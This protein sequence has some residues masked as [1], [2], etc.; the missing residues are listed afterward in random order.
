VGNTAPEVFT[1]QLARAAG[2]RANKFLYKRG[3]QK[4]D[5]DDVIYAAL[6]WCWENRAN[7]SLTTTLET[8]F[9]N[10]VRD[11]YKKL[12]TKE[13]PLSEDTLATLNRGDETYNSAAAASSAEALINAL[14]PASKSVALL[15]LSG[16]TRR[17]MV[18]MGH[19]QYVVD[20]TQQR[21]KQLRRL[22]P[23]RDVWSAVRR[24]PAGNGVTP[25]GPD[26]DDATDEQIA[27]I[28][29]EIAQLD[30]P[31]PTGKDCPPCWR[32]CYFEGYM[33]SGKRETRMAIVD[34]EVREAVKSTEARKIEIAQ[35]VRNGN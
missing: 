7:Y 5:R 24:G 31:P 14:T 21:I 23:S 19:D 13:L 28:D 29:R 18:E 26:S 27:G 17:E 3:L 22:L 33:P 35:Q 32:C 10:A 20:S 12:R 6:A 30:F 25:Q 4:A 1:I 11:A 34:A 2:G 9:V 8:W 15:I 16:R